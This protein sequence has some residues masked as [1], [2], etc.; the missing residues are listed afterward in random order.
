MFIELIGVIPFE[1]GE[2]PMLAAEAHER[3]LHRRFGHLQR[4]ERGWVGSEW[5]TTAADLMDFITAHTTPPAKLGLP[6]T[7]GRP[8]YNPDR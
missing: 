2:R 7:I 5:F 4:F 6:N 3:E 8:L 1:D